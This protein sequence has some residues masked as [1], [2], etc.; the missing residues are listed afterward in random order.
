[1]RFVVAL[2]LRQ[3]GRDDVI[4][5]DLRELH[6]VG[7]VP[8]AHEFGEDSAGVDRHGPGLGNTGGRHIG[9]HLRPVARGV[10]D[11]EHLVPRHQSA[12]GRKRH[13]DARQGASNEQRLPPRLLDG[14]DPFGVVPGV[15]LAGPRD[16]DRLG[17]VLVDLRDEWA[18]RPVG[19]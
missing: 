19:D 11:A 10:D 8:G 4:D 5:H 6:R 7:P 3:V 14:L 18:V 16:V 13:A 9:R 17:V 12:E 2:R 1:L 15:N